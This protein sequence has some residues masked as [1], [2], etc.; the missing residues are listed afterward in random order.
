MLLATLLLFAFT[1]G[2]VDA[3]VGGG[4]LIQLPAL[5]ILYPSLPIGSVL[6][7]HKLAGLCG[8]TVAVWRFASQI[9][10]DR[11]ILG[12]AA[13]VAFAGAFA[14]AKLAT[15]LPAQ[16]MKPMI[17]LLLVGVLIF[18][19]RRP[20]FGATETSPRTWMHPSAIASL[21]G[22]VLGFYDGFFGPGTGSF[23]IIAF[24]SFFGMDFLGASARAKVVNWATNFSAFLLFAAEGAVRYELALPMA[25]ANMAGAVVGSHLALTRGN[26]FVR[27]FFISVVSLMILR[28]GWDLAMNG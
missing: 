5:L 27:V 26:Q 18:T 10:F 2:F 25:A 13:A 17:V 22:L 9:E 4:G 12:P 8:T 6:G 3:V 15:L 19:V 28:L 20:S 23:L 24:I 1:A 21:I 16:V 14:G 11:R 7:T